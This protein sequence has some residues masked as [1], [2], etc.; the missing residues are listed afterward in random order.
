MRRLNQWKVA[1]SIASVSVICLVGL[2]SRSNPGFFM[3][4]FMAAVWADMQSGHLTIHFL[5]NV[6]GMKLW[7]V[8]ISQ[9][10]GIPLSEISSLPLG[11]A[12]RGLFYLA[13]VHRIT[14]RVDLAAGAGLVT[15]MFPW[16]GWGYNSVFVHSLGGFFFLSL[17]LLLM[18]VS[19][20]RH[21]PSHSLTVICILLALYFFD[22]TA[23]VWTGT[24]LVVLL[25]VAYLRPTL[26]VT[27]IGILAAL[28]A[29]LYTPK[30]TVVGYVNLLQD[31]NPVSIF[32]EYFGAES[33]NNSTPY[34]Y[35]T[36]GVG[37]GLASYYYL[38]IGVALLI[39]CFAF[40]YVVFEE[41]SLRRAFARLSTHELVLGSALVGGSTVI[42]LYTFLGLFA[43]FFIFVMGGLTGILAIWYGVQRLPHIQHRQI[44]L[45]ALLIATMVGIVGI[46]F[47]FQIQTTDMEMSEE[48]HNHLSAWLGSHTKSPNVTSGLMTAGKM[49]MSEEKNN[50]DF[51]WIWFTEQSYAAIVEKGDTQRG[52]FVLNLS[53]T[54][55]VRTIGGWKAFKPFREY[56]HT[57][58]TNSH[59]NRIYCSSNTC[60][61]KSNAM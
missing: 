51:R 10:T 33:V 13:I 44:M 9:T 34:D 7:I 8:F 25:G 26:R 47:A 29:I 16:A 45:T 12:I 56:T 27:F 36:E 57:V 43:G 11:A 19:D 35:V 46:E 53:T 39:Y 37:L 58:N 3:Q 31:T 2:W 15:L 30:H 5:S 6:P 24:M 22:Y 41:G 32:L 14:Q 17:I 59:I 28:A 40:V 20:S 18:V 4:N 49:R 21:T 52:Y 1:I 61:F 48:S 54:K 55:G 60:V 50:G 23:S 38:L 42:L